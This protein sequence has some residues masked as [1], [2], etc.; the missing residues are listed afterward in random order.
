MKTTPEQI[1]SLIRRISMVQWRA[2]DA[3]IRESGLTQIQGR[4]IGFIDA[5][6]DRGVIARDLAEASGTTAASVASL[7]S[8]LEERGLVERR[9]APDDAR[10]KLLFATP[11]AVAMTRDFAERMNAAYEAAFAVLTDDE[12]D[13]LVALLTRVAEAND[14]EDSPGR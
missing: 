12:Q 4:A 13:Q 10:R 11:A 3:W 7:I 6:Q 8:G 9:P 2:A 14:I 1:S 5:H